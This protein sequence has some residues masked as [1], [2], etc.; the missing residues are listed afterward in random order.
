[1]T[2]HLREYG[3]A[4]TLSRNGNGR[5]SLAAT[6]L[7]M[8]LL[9]LLWALLSPQMP[10]EAVDLG[11]PRAELARI[12]TP[13]TA[14]AGTYT[15]TT[16]DRAIADL[17]AALKACDAAPAEGAWQVTR[18]EAHDA[19]G[20]AGIY[21][22]LR[23]AQLFGGRRLDVVRGS[24]ARRRRTRRLHADFALPGCLADGRQPGNARDRRPRGSRR[25]VRGPNAVALE[26]KR[27]NRGIPLLSSPGARGVRE[28]TVSRLL[29]GLFLCALLA[30]SAS[31]QGWP[32]STTTFAGGRVTLGGEFTA[33]VAP[34]DAG[35]FNYTD[36]ERSALQLIRLGVTINVRPVEGSR[37]HH[38]AARGRVDRGRT[39][40]R[41]S[42][43]RVSA[44]PSLAEARIRHPGRADPAGVRRR[45]PPSLFVGQRADRL[46]ARVAVPDSDAARRGAGQRRRADL[47]AQLRLAAKLLGRLRQLRE[48]RPARHGVPLRHRRR[49][50][51]SA[52]RRARCRWRPPSPPAPCRVPARAPRTAAP[53]SRPAW[54]SGPRPG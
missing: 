17:A 2:F 19:F 25:G 30:D 23:L 31:A 48:G 33:T 28:V 39:L 4:A 6:I 34:D 20:Q 13:L 51:R 32:D 15:V 12:F 29:L 41:H 14:P 43:R 1:M 3:R 27:Y 40:E 24:L 5:I 45:R 47:R 44:R 54:P 8:V 11:Q 36:Y 46:P 38:R 18:L 26:A 42:R 52:R 9:V 16:T 35:K 49:G 53:S 50:A 22:R 21:D 7:A 37:V 10:C